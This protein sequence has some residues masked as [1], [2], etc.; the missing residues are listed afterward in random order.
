MGCS[1]IIKQANVNPIIGIEASAMDGTT[2]HVLDLHITAKG[3]S[4]EDFRNMR[5]T[6]DV[7]FRKV[8]VKPISKYIKHK[9]DY[10]TFGLWTLVVC[11]VL[12]FTEGFYRALGGLLAMC[13]LLLLAYFVIWIENKY[14][15]NMFRER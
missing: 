4:P 5:G 9:V 6:Y 15:S 7:I 11:L 3:I 8:P 13:L 14:E 1:M 2:V 10:G 12:F